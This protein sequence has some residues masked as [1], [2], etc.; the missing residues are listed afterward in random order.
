MELA[1]MRDLGSRAFGVGVQIPIPAPR[2]RGLRIVR[3]GF[4]HPGIRRLLRNT[5]LLP[6]NPGPLPG[7][8]GFSFSSAAIRA[9][10]AFGRQDI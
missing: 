4:F 2:R 1:D 10:S 7:P 8:V 5:S 3:G 6:T 9:G